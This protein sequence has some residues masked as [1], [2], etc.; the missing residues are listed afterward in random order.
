MTAL[1]DCIESPA[2]SSSARFDSL[3]ETTGTP[4]RRLRDAMAAAR[5]S[6]AWLG[7]QKSLTPEQRAQAAEAFDAER[8]F[9]SAGK[10]LLDVKHPAFR[11]VTALRGKIRD[12]WRSIS[13]PFP[14][15]GVRLIRQDQVAAFAARMTEFRSELD[16]AAIH[17]D[18]H[19]G[20]LRRAAAVRLGRL[21][22]P[23]D[24]PESLLGLFAVSFDF[25]AIDPPDYLWALAPELYEQERVKVAARFEEAARLAEQAFIDEFARLVTHLTERLSGCGEEGEPKVF[26]DSAVNNLVEFFE[27][28]RALSVRGN[29]Q[30]D[31]L[32]AQAQRATRGASAQGI[33]DNPS[34]R[35]RVAEQLAQT[36]SALER[37]LVDRPRRRILRQAS[38]PENF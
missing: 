15:P 37:L 9:L 4:A 25:P 2:S 24:Y 33:R 32:V 22:N 30:L 13:L 5:V 14:E 3:G 21:Y 11:A 31:E 8:Q 20:E 6:F 27:R 19:Y 16:Q 7:T 23:E 34:L 36:Q 38:T 29:D 18:R 12:Y 17:L 1:L 10:K 28:F 35:R 26:R